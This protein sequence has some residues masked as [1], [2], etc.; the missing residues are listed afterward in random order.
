M[1]SHRPRSL[2]E[3]DIEAIA[4]AVAEATGSHKVFSDTPP[5]IRWLQKW[6]WKVSLGIA[7]ESLGHV[8]HE[9]IRRGGHW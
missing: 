2:S 9:L 3:H 5:T 7:A 1:D 6:W 8:I 4:E